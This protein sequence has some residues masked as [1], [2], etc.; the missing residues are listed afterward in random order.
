MQA[1]R[2]VFK[3]AYDAHAILNSTVKNPG[4]VAAAAA[5]KSG[6]DVCTQCN[7]A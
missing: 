6:I 4:A 5:A 2:F 1:Q 3:N 7:A